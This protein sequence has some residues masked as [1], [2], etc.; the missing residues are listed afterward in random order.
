MKKKMFL[1]TSLSEK[2]SVRLRNIRHKEITLERH[3]FNPRTQYIVIVVIHIT[4]NGVEVYG[5]GGRDNAK[6]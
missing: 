3:Y 2:L 4:T 1:N 6:I 5:G